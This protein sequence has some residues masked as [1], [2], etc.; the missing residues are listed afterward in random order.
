MDAQTYDQ[1]NVGQLKDD[2]EARNKDRA[3]ADK[4]TS[5]SGNKADLIKALQLDDERAAGVVPPDATEPAQ[6][7]TDAAGEPKEVV[8]DLVTLAHPEHDGRVQVLK[9]SATYTNYVRGYGYRE[10]TAS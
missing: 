3:D 1:K 6:A 2:I 4:I 9:P 8:Q 10:E 5:P 7:A